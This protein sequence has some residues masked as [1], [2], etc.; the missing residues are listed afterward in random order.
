MARIQEVSLPD[1]YAIGV[2]DI[3]ELVNIPM[4]SNLFSI[5]YDEALDSFMLFIQKALHKIVSIHP[6]AQDFGLCNDNTILTCPIADDLLTCIVDLIN[7]ARKKVETVDIELTSIGYP[8]KL[9]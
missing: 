3:K 9:G 6:K 4:I 2:V 7:T 1:P 8:F 5:P